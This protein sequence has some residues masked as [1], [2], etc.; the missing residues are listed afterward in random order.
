MKYWK[1]KDQSDENAGYVDG[2]PATGVQGSIPPAE[3]FE[4]PMRE[5]QNLIIAA[6]LT[7]DGSILTQVAAAVAALVGA[8]GDAIQTIIDNRA[9]T[10]SIYVKD[11]GDDANDGLSSLAPLRTIN[12][13]IIRSKGYRQVLITMLSDIT[14]STAPPAVDGTQIIMQPDVGTRTLNIA[15][16]AWVSDGDGARRVLRFN[17]LMYLTLDH[18]NLINNVTEP[19]VQGIAQCGGGIFNYQFGQYSVVN[20]SARSFMV[21]GNLLGVRLESAT[22]ANNNASDKFLTGVST[23]QNPNSYWP[24]RSNVATL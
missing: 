14:I 12:E 17:G 7:P 5:L 11:V 3:A 24:Y 6:G 20:G 8:R 22:F 21:S 16:N 13:A 2:N 1:P 10:A 4:Q 15:A 19:T 9:G 23:G 18:I